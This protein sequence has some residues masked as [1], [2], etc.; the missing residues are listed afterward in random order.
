MIKN[1]LTVAVAVALLA[2]GTSVLAQTGPV[3]PQYQFPS[4][5]KE[6]PGAVQ[7]G[8]S[9]L[10]MAPFF[11]FSAGQDDNVTLSPSN[12]QSS[13]V[14]IFNPGV[15][16]DAR[17]PN[18]VF[19]VG[20]QAKIGRYTDSEAD[21][22]VDHTTRSSFD[23]AFSPRSAMRLGYD[24]LIGHD[25][26]GATDRGLSA[27]P[28]KYT[29]KT[30]SV[31]YAVGGQGAQGNVELFYSDAIKRYT[32]NR[33]TTFASDRDTQDFG[34]AFYWRVM[35]KTKVLV[36]A[37]DTH[38]SYLQ[39]N[40][41]FSGDETRYYGGVTWEATAATSG[42]V[43]VGYLKKRFDGDSPTYSGSSWEA[44]VSWL[45]RTYSK[46][47]FYTSRQPTESTGLGSFILSDAAGAVWTHS[48][49][50]AIT[51]EANFRYQ[52]DDYQDF[53]RNDDITT[54]GLKVG[55]AWRRWLKFGVEYNYTKRDSNLQEN[56]YKRNIF[57]FT[58]SATM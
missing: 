48:W 35:P 53:D 14:Y 42:T 47:D 19:V 38:L 21:N 17:D 11:N 32:N 1:K 7:M 5:Q 34:G 39:T 58:A 28:D 13:P 8:D 57:L 37:R 23:M 22:Y 54:V 55:Y 30:P 46:F 44:Q 27:V 6:G 41:P 2:M 9:P 50:S 33:G 52:K 25:G 29:L 26:R 56:D 45:P 3:R 40:S 36:E 49:T 12:E 18:K 43:K 10:Y 16:F 20:Y 4:A 24:Y 31:M 15:T 51:T